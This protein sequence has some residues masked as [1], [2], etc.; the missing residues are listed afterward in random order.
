MWGNKIKSTNN[1]GS[2]KSI[3]S[4]SEGV[5]CDYRAR[6]LGRPDLGRLLRGGRVGVVIDDA[7]LICHYN[8]TIPESD[9]KRSDI[10]QSGQNIAEGFRAVPPKIK[11]AIG[12]I[13]GPVIIQ[14]DWTGS[15]ALYLVKCVNEDGT[16]YFI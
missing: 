10:I 16:P 14:H 6:G 8:N 3:R 4:E 5:V 11:T 9:Q 15:R 2:E 1:G 12:I 13:G 7:E